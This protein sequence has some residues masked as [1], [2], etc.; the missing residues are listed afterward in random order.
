ME[1]ESTSTNIYIQT[2]LLFHKE[3]LVIVQFIVFHLF[4]QRYPLHFITLFDDM[5]RSSNSLFKKF[6]KIV[7]GMT[8]IMSKFE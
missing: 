3:A 7:Q 8:N 4:D 5:S 6:L 1:D 2:V